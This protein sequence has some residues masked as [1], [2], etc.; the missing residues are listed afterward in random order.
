MRKRTIRIA[1]VFG[2]SF[3]ML[4]GCGTAPGDAEKAS[5]GKAGDEMTEQNAGQVERETLVVGLQT[6]SFVTDY[7]DN[8]M[9]KKIEDDLN[10]NLEIYQLP[11]AGKDV[12]TKVSLMATNGEDIPDILITN[13]LTSEAVLDYGTKGIFIPLNEY[14]EREDTNFSRIVEEDKQSILRAITMAD[15][16]I[17]ALPK[18]VDNLWNYT[19]NRMYINTAWLEKLGLNVPETTD[20]LYEVLKAFHENDPNGNGVQDELGA[21]GYISGTYG[22]D[23]VDTIMNAFVFYNGAKKNNGLALDETGEQVIAPFVTDGWKKGLEYMNMLYEEGLLAPSVFTDDLSQFRATLNSETNVVG[24]VS[25]G[26]TANW[27]DCD[28]NANFLEMSM[29][30]PLKGPDGICYTPNE[31]TSSSPAFMITSQCKNPD[32]AFLVGDWFMDPEHSR[33]ARYGEKNVDW[34]DDPEICSQNTNAYL[35]AGLVDSINCVWMTNIWSEPSNKFWKNINPYYE[36]MDNVNRVASGITP[37]DKSTKSGMLYAY[38]LEWYSDK[39]PEYM[40]E[41]LHYTM[42]EAEQL[43][44]IMMNVS[45][46]VEQ[47]KAEFITGEREIKTE[48]DSYLSEMQNLG[49]NTWLEVAQTAYERE[50]SR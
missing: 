39:H 28:N 42:E 50:Q 44:E 21:Y 16:T 43:T 33:I 8:Y 10:V 36:S 31:G 9:T 6:D 13:A 40:L 45:E 30:P 47:S 25:A 7:E 27:T 29:I 2:L 4:G 3:C 14:L 41:T 23:I 37:F 49:L 38:N 1:A 12:Q 19:P 26:S 34:T 18:F 35:E 46:F 48:W 17:Y 15:G 11:S 32:L 5:A 20:E 22:E 24:V